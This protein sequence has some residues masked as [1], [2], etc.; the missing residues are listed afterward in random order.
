MLAALYIFEQMVG[1]TWE[2]PF[3]AEADV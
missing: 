1:K 2:V 3:V